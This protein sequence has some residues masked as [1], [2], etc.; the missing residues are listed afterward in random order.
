[1]ILSYISDLTVEISLCV[2]LKGNFLS[3][4]GKLNPPPPSKKLHFTSLEIQLI[5][6]ETSFFCFRRDFN[7]RCTLDEAKAEYEKSEKLEQAFGE[8]FTAVITGDS[9]DE[10]FD[11]VKEVIGEQSGPVI[12]V[13]Q[14]EP[15]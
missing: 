7:K 6:N 1:M 11:K 3:K 13:P 8:H 10:L 2:R 15:L 4:E 14:K 9:F 12:W 5:F